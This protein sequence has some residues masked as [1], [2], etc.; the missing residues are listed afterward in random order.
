MGICTA[1]P[2]LFLEVQTFKISREFQ[3]V[4]NVEIV[5][6]NTSEGINFFYLLQLPVKLF[7]CFLCSLSTPV[8]ILVVW[9]GGRSWLMVVV[10]NVVEVESGGANV[11][12]VYG[13]GA[14]GGSAA[15][16][17]VAIAS[18]MTMVEMVEPGG[19]LM[20]LL[21]LVVFLVVSFLFHGGLVGDSGVVNFTGVLGCW[22]TVGMWW[23]RW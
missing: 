3:T 15:L 9:Y 5:K 13:D 22:S 4:V 17:E 16:A 6:I 12:A 19:A 7:Y 20:V 8:E 2:I 21:V 1:F 11:V 14:C 23:C 10:L 18:L